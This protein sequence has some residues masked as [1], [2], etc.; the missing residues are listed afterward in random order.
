M[1][2]KRKYHNYYC[3]KYPTALVL[4]TP[5]RLKWFIKNILYLLLL[6]VVCQNSFLLTL[7]SHTFLLFIFVYP[8]VSCIFSIFFHTSV[9]LI[10]FDYFLFCCLFSL[11]LFICLISLSCLVICSNFFF[12]SGLNFFIF[13]FHELHFKASEGNYSLPLL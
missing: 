11:Y 4:Y 7:E 2:D 5:V 1:T 3:N 8:F 6:K 13:R 9:F 12:Y 10:L